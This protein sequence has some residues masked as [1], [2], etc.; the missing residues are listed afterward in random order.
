MMIHV[1]VLFSAAMDNQ[2]SGGFF[3]PSG[4]P[5]NKG[6]HIFTDLRRIIEN[7]Y[8]RSSLTKCDRQ[9]KTKRLSIFFKH[10]LRY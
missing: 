6:T 7:Y 9:V 8:S 3:H 2:R 1:F 5:C 10:L 4:F